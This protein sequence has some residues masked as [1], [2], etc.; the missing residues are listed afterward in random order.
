MVKRYEDGHVCLAK[1]THQ[2]VGLPLGGVRLSVSVCLA[3]LYGVFHKLP[4][5]GLLLGGV[6]PIQYVELVLVIHER[7]YWLFSY[8][9]ELLEQKLK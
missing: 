5:F 9:A 8:E 1:H 2:V 3:S 7:E 6:C 4:L